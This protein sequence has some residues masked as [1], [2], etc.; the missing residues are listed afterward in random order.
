MPR[1]YAWTPSD[2]EECIVK[3]EGEGFY[4]AIVRIAEGDTSERNLRAVFYAERDVNQTDHTQ[5]F[6]DDLDS[7]AMHWVEACLREYLGEPDAQIV[8]AGRPLFRK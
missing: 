7:G 1:P 2:E 4:G 3:I 8:L 6:Q 5:D